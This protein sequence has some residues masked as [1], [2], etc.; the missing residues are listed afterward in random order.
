MMALADASPRIE[1]VK[2]AK[3]FVR[4]NDDGK[5]VLTNVADAGCPLRRRTCAGLEND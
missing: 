5:I 2:D 3:L 4:E 1:T